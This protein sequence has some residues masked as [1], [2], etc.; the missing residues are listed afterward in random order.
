MSEELSKE[1]PITQS[2]PIIP[3]YGEDMNMP[4]QEGGRPAVNERQAN[5]ADKQRYQL[6]LEKITKAQTA[7]ITNI[8]EQLTYEEIDDFGSLQAKFSR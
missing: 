8:T 4:R 7:G 2:G 3:R 1:L 6:Y 5:I